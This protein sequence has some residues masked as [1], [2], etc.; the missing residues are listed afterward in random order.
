MRVIFPGAQ[1][2]G[3]DTCCQKQDFPVQLGH[4]TRK[5]QGYKIPQHFYLFQLDPRVI[6]SDGFARK[7]GQ[8]LFLKP[9][10]PFLKLKGFGGLNY[11]GHNRS[12]SVGHD[13][14]DRAILRKKID[15]TYIFQNQSGENRSSLISRQ[16]K[17]K[18]SMKGTLLLKSYCIYEMFIQFLFYLVKKYSLG[19][20]CNNNN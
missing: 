17:V 10:L 1:K 11:F 8:K 9:F 6:F 2:M 4:K 20:K 7:V 18:F 13:R 5:Y 19:Y 14:H 3:F 15:L 16:S 12:F